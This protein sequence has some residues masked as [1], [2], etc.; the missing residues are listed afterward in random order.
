MLQICKS[1]LIEFAPTKEQKVNSVPGVV[2]QIKDT[3]THDRQFFVTITKCTHQ[4]IYIFLYMV[5]GQSS[6]DL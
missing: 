4:L 6:Y 1:V 3:K 2:S 5:M